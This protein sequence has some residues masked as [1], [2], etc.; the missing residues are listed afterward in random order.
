MPTFQ[1]F[2][3]KLISLRTTV[4]TEFRMEVEVMAFMQMHKKK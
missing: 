2:Y 4:M 3:T 1:N